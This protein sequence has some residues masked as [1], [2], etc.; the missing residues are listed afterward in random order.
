ML[1]ITFQSEIK[2][3]E[4]VLNTKAKLKDC[5]SDTFLKNNEG[6]EITLGEVASFALLN[7]NGEVE[8]KVKLSLYNIAKSINQNETI[9]IAESSLTTITNLVLSTA[10]PLVG[11]AFYDEVVAQTS[12]GSQEL[13]VGVETPIAEVVSEVQEAEDHVQTC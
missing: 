6:K 4:F 10:T 11:G 2:M 9:T 13:E 1:N 5:F 8:P 12:V 7:F 3:T